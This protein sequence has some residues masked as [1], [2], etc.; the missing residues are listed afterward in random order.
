MRDFKKTYHY[1][2]S[3]VQIPYAWVDILHK[4]IEDA[5]DI[6]RQTFMRRVNTIEMRHLADDMGYARSG[7]WG[8]LTLAQDWLVSYHKSKFN[9]VVCYYMRH[10]AVEHIFLLAKDRERFNKQMYEESRKMY[11]DC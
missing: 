5:T 6:T 2:R 4:C 11:S 10:S 8:D 3:C 7:R 9:G 1:F